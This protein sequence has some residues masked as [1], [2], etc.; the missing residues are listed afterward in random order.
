MRAAIY[1]RVSTTGQAEEGHS[2]E[3]QERQCRALIDLH[4]HTISNI[5]SDIGSGK[6]FEHRPGYLAMLEGMNSEWDILYVWKL[7]RL[8]RSIRNAVM[9]F[10][11]IGKRDAY[12][13]SVTENT[14]TSTPAGRFFI[15]LM[16]AM[17]QMERE[18]I[19]E[20]VTMGL[21]S[22]RN[23]G[24]WTGGVPYGYSIPIE[25]DDQGNRKNRGLLQP[26]EQE[27]EIVKLIFDLR[28]KGN[29]VSK[30]CNHLTSQGIKTRNGNV[31][32]TPNTIN[33]ILARADL[34]YS[35]LFNG[36]NYIPLFEGKS[37]LQGGEENE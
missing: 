15:N 14:D 31:I 24:R 33:T 20:R 26:N 11:E 28:S 7:D 1:T 27:K 9:F 32:W 29:K 13:A 37:P 18:Q 25:Y 4:G 30:I 2:L 16:S 19:S 17:A 21:Q 3:E 6:G 22:A 8:N 34:Y 12:F 5:Y 23:T 36:Y 35:G 10:D